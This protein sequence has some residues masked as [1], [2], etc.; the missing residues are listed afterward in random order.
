MQVTEKRNVT[1]LDGRACSKTAMVASPADVAWVIRKS[2]VEALLF[3]PLRNPEE[4]NIFQRSEAHIFRE[5]SER[6]ICRSRFELCIGA[7]TGMGTYSHVG[8]L[9]S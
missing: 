7:Q 3:P 6:N 8:L 9:W 2:L 4:K 1:F 5:A